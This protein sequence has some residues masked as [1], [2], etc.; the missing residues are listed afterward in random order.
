MIPYQST[1]KAPAKRLVLFVADGLRADKFYELDEHGKT[2]APYL[3][4]LI[5]TKASW[6]VSHTRVPTESRPGHVALIA[7]F[8][9]D[10]SAVAKGWKENP[11]EF[12]STFNES[13]YTWAWGSPDIL[14][15]FAKGASGDHVFTSMYEDV[16]EDFANEDAA[17]LDTWVFNEVRNFFSAARNNETLKRMLHEEKI[18]FF[19]HLLGIDTNGHAHRPTSKEYL[20]NIAVVDKGVKEM[21][22]VIEEFYGH[23]HGTAFVLTAD[24]GMTN[25]GSHGAGH[26]HET[27]TPLVAWGAGVQGPMAPVRSVD[28]V[29]ETIRWN[30]GHLKR[31][32][33][34]QADIA[35]L[36]TSLIGV[37]FPLNSVGI[38][39]LDYLN[40]SEQYLAE[41]LFMNSQ[42]ILAQYDVK[43]LFRKETSLWF[44]PF[45]SLA[46]AK[47]TGMIRDIKEFMRATKYKEAESLSRD[48]INLALEGLN[49]YQNY[50]RVFLNLVVTLG[51][52]GWILC[53]ILQIV[54]DH[55]EVIK[56][57]SKLGKE[58]L[59][60][61]VKTAPLDTATLVLAFLA[62]IL[63]IIQKAPWMYYSYCLM[64]LVFWN[65]IAKRLHVV[66]A[67]WSYIREKQLQHR[68]L[69]TFLFGSFSLEILVMSFFRREILSVGLVCL[70]LWPF[71][72]QLYK[73]CTPSVAGW[74][75]LSFALSVFPLLP[76]VGREANYFLVTAAGFLTLIIFCSL[77]FY[78]S[79]V[80]QLMNT[81]L[82]KSCKILLLQ[83]LLTALAI[84]I[85]NSTAASL[86]RKLGLPLVNQL[87]SWTILVSSFLLP[88]IN[89]SNL[90]IRLSSIAMAFSSLYLLMS[91]AYESLFLLV[92]SLLMG[93]WLLS[94]HKLS[95]KTLDALLETQ[96]SNASSTTTYQP[97]WKALTRGMDAPVMRKLT[98]ED[99][100][101]AY[102]FVFFIVV[103]F[104]GTG[105]IASINSFDPASVYCFL[106]VFSP[107]V[108]GSLLLC[109]VLIPFVIVTCAFDAIHVVLSIPVQSLVLVV[110][111]MTDL[112]GLHFFFLVQDSGSW[113]DIGTSISHFVIMMAFIIFLLPIF[114][115]ARLFTGASLP[116][117]TSKKIA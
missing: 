48:L 108:M 32:D 22:N 99:L 40:N 90:T 25:W 18:V 31:I 63:L 96:L 51:F 27:L 71:T 50:D 80:S 117:R 97:A 105:N 84:Y 110:L 115:L 62:V 38:L 94:E 39:P 101:C 70:A 44:Q 76:V 88:L 60:P 59:Q 77:L 2:R 85:V 46:G 102:F 23:D 68:V 112:M 61:L 57:A 20:R 89:S 43:E 111:V 67:A 11:V 109:K 81:E 104:F 21:E 30:L 114:G 16:A 100:R 33:V 107:F 37:P 65:R 116:F 93:A 83:A 98:L 79:T 58:N 34:N 69:F 29:E 24:H 7:G 73:T 78:V 36:M 17:K 10:V 91:T 45:S 72:T 41:N 86:K 66:R 87:G 3:R 64:P 8:Y 95:G 26:P 54:E 5:E 56:E 28:I 6:G 52:L 113:L 103:A 55:S 42:Q 106:T 49:Y 1:L 12:D 75:S 4:D 47:K 15:M 53:I 35:P 9:E 19:F 13:R 92:L 82:T 14:P 74:M